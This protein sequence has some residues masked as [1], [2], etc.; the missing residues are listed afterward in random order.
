KTYREHVVQRVA[1][2]AMTSQQAIARMDAARWVRRVTYHAWRI[3]YHLRKEMPP[4]TEPVIDSPE[5][6]SPESETLENDSP[7]TDD[8]E[9]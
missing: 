9:T 5:D 8:P 4:E 1:S 3:A 2:R 7:A 6:D